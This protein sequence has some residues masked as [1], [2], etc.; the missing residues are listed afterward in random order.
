MKIISRRG[1]QDIQIQIPEVDIELDL[2]DLD[3]PD[4]TDEAEGMVQQELDYEDW[5]STG[6]PPIDNN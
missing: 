5:M 4:G 2:A 3:A 1:K 6:F